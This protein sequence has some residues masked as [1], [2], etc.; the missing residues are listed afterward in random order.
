MYLKKVR[1]YGFKSFAD[2]VVFEFNPGITAVVG[3]NG[4]GKS[5][6]L[7][8]V[9]WVLGEQSAGRL[10]GSEMQDMIFKGSKTRKP[11]GFASVE[12]VLD[13]SRDLLPVEYSEVTVGRKLYRSGE[14]EYY[15]NRGRCRLKDIKELFMDTGIGT[16]SYSVMEQDNIRFI[17]ESSPLER[18]GIIEEAAGIRKY[19]EKKLEAER[20]LERTRADLNEVK[21]IMGEV[22][23]NI[24]RLR[25]QRSRA[26]K[27]RSLREKL[28][29]LEVSRLCQ[30]YVKAE[31]ELKNEQGS[32]TGLDEK[33][34]ALAAQK[35]TLDARTAE[36]EEKRSG[37]EDEL[38]EANRS[39]YSIE[40][41]SKVVI[42]RIEGFESSM[43]RL[44][45]E[46]ER[47]AA[48][49]TYNDKN[50]RQL[51]EEISRFESSR[52]TAREKVVSKLD[53][54]IKELTLKKAKSAEE[55]GALSRKLEELREELLT[56]RR[57]QFETEKASEVGRETLDKA[58]E[59]RT[60]LEASAS[61]AGKDLE[62]LSKQLAAREKELESYSGKISDLIEGIE[63]LEEKIR[64]AG[65]KR[66]KL[67]TRY[68]ATKS[69]FDAGKKYLPQL[70]SIESLAGSGIKGVKG[71]VSALL[72]KAMDEKSFMKI[73]R[74]AGGRL[75]WM[76][77]ADKGSALKAA[78]FLKDRSL[79]PLT[80]II[81]EKLPAPEDPT[82]LAEGLS[83]DL[84]AAACYLVRDIRVEDDLIWSG[85]CLLTGGGPSPRRSG[86]IL[87]LESDI[88][89]LKKELAECTAAA[90]DLRKEKASLEEKLKDYGEKETAARDESGK[91]KGACGKLSGQLH[92]LESEIN[93]LDGEIARLR[94]ISEKTDTGKEVPDRIKSVSEEISRL[95]SELSEKQRILEDL[96]EKT[97][98]V[99]G[100]RTALAQAL[101]EKRSKYESA[102]ERKKELEK[103]NLRLRDLI[104]DLKAKEQADIR[105][106]DRDIKS[107]GELE[108]KRGK[109]REEISRL[110]VKKREIVKELSGIRQ[111]SRKA[112]TALTQ[113]REAAGEKRQRQ[114]R[115]KERIISI[116]R[117]LS[118]DMNTELDVA[119]K[120]YSREPVTQEDIQ[121]LK[122]KLEKIGEVNL[123]AP[124]EF[125]RES[126][127]F[128]FIKKQLD[129]LETADADIRSIIRK[130]NR[131][132]REKFLET[133]NA[134]SGNFSRIFRKLFEGGS[135]SLS[136]TEPGDVLESGIDIKARPEGKSVTSLMSIS[137]GESALTAIALMFAVY[138]VKPTPFCVLDEVDS[139]LDDVNLHRFLKMLKDYSDKTQFIVIT[140]NKQT[141]QES[142]TF[143]GV[144]MEEFGVSKVISVNLKDV[145]T[146]SG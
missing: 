46:I 87:G 40:S 24:R 120:S 9:S 88:E 137:G 36:L 67:L 143:Y 23:K 54:E 97:A 27:F 104:K 38:L 57:S 110:E 75:G 130:I 100:R 65:E 133:F 74:A 129:D 16:R 4:C 125:E 73:S 144:T 109:A 146:S 107:V 70:M 3:P 71:P 15:I 44:R 79:P 14:S 122:E 59:K 32:S 21:N 25:R 115:L 105:T 140:H 42:N 106:H 45:Q 64:A 123:A 43:E 28:R 113:V 121:E 34:S 82:G 61:D 94:K 58:L 136:L 139:P 114:E 18:R 108:S 98:E 35:A 116:R 77:A 96:S 118:E 93:S 86:R 78:S 141:M 80:F 19:R 69:E 83:G 1:I 91:L 17:L 22:Q 49:I 127:R 62:S 111:E 47:A 30:E 103:D 134:V 55:T 20:N 48:G 11:L 90:G 52:D 81:R 33:I 145:K 101:D 99:R 124:E 50:I 126:E 41:D 135:A 117:R 89:D 8:A 39:V 5:N 119:L 112:E 68:H 128:E 85:G 142:D 12:L 72:E 2:E 60:L 53:S 95:S 131:Q 29:G 63:G 56:L 7:D 13:N 92:F 31:D 26:E 84:R 132:T 6:V 102:V 138:E 76:L 66:E 37:I 51:E 10:R